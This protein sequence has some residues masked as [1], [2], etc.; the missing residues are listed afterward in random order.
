MCKAWRVV[1]G[2]ILLVFWAAVFTVA[3]HTSSP[4]QSPAMPSSTPL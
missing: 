2:V 4:G 3:F 1:V